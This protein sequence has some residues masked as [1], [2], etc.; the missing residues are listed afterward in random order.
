[1]RISAKA[2]YAVRAAIELAA[3]ESS[4]ATKAE[5][6]AR[7]QD[8][9]HKFLEGIL[10][11]LRRAGLVQSVRGLNGGYHLALPASEISVADVVRAVDGPLMSVR[12][13]RPPELTYSGRA[14]P[15]LPLWVALRANVRA[16]LESVSLADLASADLPSEVLDLADDALAWENP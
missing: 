13:A 14:E 1:M 8:I 7:A 16:V 12:G 4:A 10:G 5:A 2:D 6:I 9:P 15:L 11:D 3:A